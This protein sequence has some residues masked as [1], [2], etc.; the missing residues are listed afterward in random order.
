MT[1]AGKEFGHEA[2]KLAR[3]IA[4]QLRTLASL[5][6]APSGIEHYELAAADWEQRADRWEALDGPRPRTADA[7]PD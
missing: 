5:C 2:P 7:R 4:V 6:K 1:T 3:E